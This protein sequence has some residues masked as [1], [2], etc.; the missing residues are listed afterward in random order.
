MAFGFGSHPNCLNGQ[1]P[2]GVLLKVVR[3]A[4]VLRLARWIM[5][6]SE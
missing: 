5:S 2:L 3:V 4:E 1:V 6:A